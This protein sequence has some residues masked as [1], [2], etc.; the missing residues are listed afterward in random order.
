MLQVIFNV[1]IIWGM[2]GDISLGNI[3]IIDKY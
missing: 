2:M 1:H 3:V